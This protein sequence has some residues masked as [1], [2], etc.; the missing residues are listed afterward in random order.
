MTA[1]FQ[2]L[3]PVILVLAVVVAQI[4]KA[5]RRMSQGSKGR[6][7]P[8]DG[9]PAGPPDELRDFLQA[10][11]AGRMPPEQPTP[12]K[13]PPL[14]PPGSPPVQ[15]QAAPAARK[16][17]RPASE[18]RP[19]AAQA[20]PA[21]RQTPPLAAQVSRPTPRATEQRVHVPTTERRREV[22]T[23]LAAAPRPETYGAHRRPRLVAPDRNAILGDLSERR[24]LAKAVLLRE[25]LG[26]PLGLRR[27]GP[28][29]AEGR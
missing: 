29:A 14:P 2:Q 8:P 11:A 23:R 28:P 18:A 16:A 1:G 22:T 4:V 21:A 24:S 3:F 13:P 7:P 9:P 15:R 25:I 20:R 10:L 12:A 19:P 27:T 5:A 6:P 26:R 17:P